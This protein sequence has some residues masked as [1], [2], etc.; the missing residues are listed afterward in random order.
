MSG[1]QQ[2]RLRRLVREHAPDLPERAEGDQ[3]RQK[4]VRDP[5][6]LEIV[7]ERRQRRLG[8]SQRGVMQ[9]LKREHK[10]RGKG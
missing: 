7:V 6:G 3:I 5:N 2:K 8:P 4:V 9:Q 1:K 10:R